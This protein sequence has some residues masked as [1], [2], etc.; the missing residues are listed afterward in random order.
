MGV[1]EGKRPREAPISES[2]W[3]K[4]RTE[5]QIW[6]AELAKENQELRAKLGQNSTN[7]SRPPSS[8]PP[9]TKKPKPRKGRKKRSGKKRRPGGQP[10]HEGHRRPL[11]PPEQVDQ[12]EEIRPSHCGGCDRKLPKS[13]PTVG[14]PRRH[15]TA[16][17][18]D[19]RCSIH[20]YTLHGIECEDC[21]ETTYAELPD[22]ATPSNFGPNLRAFIALLI[23]RYRISRR[24]TVEF[25]REVLN[26]DISVGAV[27][28]ATRRISEALK[29]PVDEVAERIKES[30]IVHVDETS[31]RQ[32]GKRLWL[33]VVVTSFAVLFRISTRC[34]G[35]A[36][37]LLGEAFAGK[38]VTDRYA[39]Y[40]QFSAD[41]RQVCWAH[42]S[43]DLKGLVDR[44]GAARRIGKEALKIK[45]KM[46]KEW[47]RYKAGE[48]RFQTLQRRLEDVEMEFGIL[49]AKGVKCRDERAAGLCKALVQVES[50]LFLFART[51]GVEPTNNAAERAIRPAVIW[52]KVCFGT[53]SARGSRF[54]ERML[55]ATMT[56]RAQGR[57][58]FDYLRSVVVAQDRG[59]PIPSLLAEPDE[60]APSRA[61]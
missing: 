36:A 16:E 53:Q 26:I 60:R 42:L 56:C 33:W 52:R 41:Q 38:L 61:A 1:R 47:H 39:V 29:D 20:E 34:R 4:L 59:D 21:G 22:G 23:G 24:M 14:E 48:I 50:S 44:G 43:R 18:P 17:I 11:V 31:W 46:F 15:Q 5:F 32:K 12:R 35:T 37:D 57:S 30:P 40:L 8:D 27:D 13:L 2:D 54:V 9:D 3:S 6:V 7:S 51:E 55:T 19:I 28:N 49:L 25:C 58:M 10:G 45:E